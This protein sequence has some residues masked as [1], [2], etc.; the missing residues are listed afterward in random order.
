MI[1]KFLVVLV[2]TVF[3]KVAPAAVKYDFEDE[4]TILTDHD[5]QLSS[6]DAELGELFEGDILLSSTQRE[7]IQ[8]AKSS[9]NVLI[10]IS[11]RWPNSTVVYQIVEED[12]DEQQINMIKEGMK[13]IEKKS[14]VIF[15][16]KDESTEEHAVTIQGT[17]RGCYASIG[18]TTGKQVYNLGEDCFY[19]RTVVHE[20]LHILG[21]HHMQNTYDRDEYVK[22]VWENIQPGQEHNFEKRSDETVT[23]F[24]LEYDYASIMHYGAT[25]FSKNGNPT[26]IPLEENVT[27]GESNELSEIDVKKINI[28][29]NCPD[30][31]Y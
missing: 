8:Q 16:P 21:F 25:D 22:I 27:I 24:G 12:F 4:K 2:L 31:K 26:I 5:D 23:D 1:L 7:A 3:S 20:F 19:H 13:D 11:T 17:G 9:R 30:E 15:R 18:Y 28:M 29:Y 10:N 14:C 6:T